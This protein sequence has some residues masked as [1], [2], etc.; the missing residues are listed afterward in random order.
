MSDAN[1]VDPVNQP[2]QAAHEVV[3][4]LIKSDVLM[5]SGN[6]SYGTS[7]GE[8]LAESAIAAHKKLTEYY[9]TLK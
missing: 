4:E 1:L 9:K 3:I 8:Q 6:S 5:S 7:R 2:E